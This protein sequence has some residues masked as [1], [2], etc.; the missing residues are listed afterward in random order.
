MKYIVKYSLKLL[1]RIKLNFILMYKKKWLY[2]CKKRLVYWS[3]YKVM[4]EYF[5][6]NYNKIE[7]FFNYKKNIISIKLFS[8]RYKLN[9][10][11]YK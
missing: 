6:K 7:G 3:L 10:K 8:I 9:M 4:K 1:M 2:L 11:I 5:W